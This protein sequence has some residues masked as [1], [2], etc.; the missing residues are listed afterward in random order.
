ME[1]NPNLFDLIAIL[2]LV[3]AVLAGIRTGALPQVG[4]IGGAVTGLLVMLN[5][6]PWLLD[7]T[8]GLEPIPRAL[9]VLGA[10]LGAV[11]LGEALGSAIG[12]AIADRLGEGVLSGMDR[13]AGGLVGA[14]QALLIIWLAG[15]LMVASPFPRLAQTA[16]QSTAVRTIDGYLPP[17]T[18]V[19]GQIAGAL[20]DSGLPDVFVGLEPIPLQPVD[21]P[22]GPA[23]RADRRQRPS[24][25]R[26]ASSR[27]PATRR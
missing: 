9:V 23:G 1:F 6:A 10:I 17:P 3:L 11:I 2:V 27:A 26:P 22:D 18:E 12:R 13:V 25:P 14:A 24:E 5:A 4:G 7:V 21:T 8:A 16:S 20:D 19:I 15:G